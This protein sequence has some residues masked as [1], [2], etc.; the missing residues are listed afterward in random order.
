M[1]LQHFLLIFRKFYFRLL[2]AIGII[3]K[4]SLGLIKNGLVL[5]LANRLVHVLSH[6]RALKGFLF[7]ICVEF[8]VCEVFVFT[9]NV[10]VSLRIF[11]EKVH[12]V[13]VDSLF[14]R[15]KQL[16][17]VSFSI[18]LEEGVFGELMLNLCS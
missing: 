11:V 1:H 3:F 9:H 16:V 8:G 2:R 7:L 12:V 6:E 13:P 14:V 15:V 5:F 4:P 18:R 17:L 10:E